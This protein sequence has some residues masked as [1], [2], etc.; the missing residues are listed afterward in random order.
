MTLPTTEARYMRI[1]RAGSHLVL[2]SSA[3]AFAGFMTQALQAQQG[4]V[5]L[6]HGAGLYTVHCARCHG[7]DGD[8]YSC[9]GD[10][11]PLA[12]MC[13]R[14]RVDMV[15][16]HMSPSYFSRGRQFEGDDARDLTAYL[17]NLKGEK[18]FDA[19]EFICLPRLLRFVRGIPKS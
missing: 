8:D 6:G 13:K 10:M 3:L 7:A 16:Q 4:A 19:P 5:D 15:A 9:S 17:C 11:T 2:S 12:G 18:G 14:P 1:I